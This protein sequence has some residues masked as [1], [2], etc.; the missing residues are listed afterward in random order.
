M[1]NIEILFTL[2]YAE[3]IRMLQQQLLSRLEPSV[4]VET[5][6][7]ERKAFDQLDAF[8]LDERFNRN[9]DTPISEA[10]HRRR[11]IYTRDFEKAFLLDREDQIRLL[12]DPINPYTRG[13]VAAANRKK[14]DLVIEA[15]DAAAI[16][17]KNGT[18]TT[19]FD[20]AFE[21]LAGGANMT[22]AKVRDAKQMLIQA[23][24]DVDDPM[25]MVSLVM[26]QDQ[27]T[28]LMGDPEVTSGD[29]NTN[30]VLVNGRLDQWYGCK[31]IQSERLPVTATVRSCFMWCKQSMKLGIGASPMSKVEQRSD[32]SYSTQAY[33]KHHYGA[34]RMDEKGVVRILCQ[35]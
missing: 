21:V 15:F 35:E 20:T 26:S 34:T 4:T 7:N 5:D 16:T 27:I 22:P 25:N 31:I 12:N 3:G 32:K 13:F 2:K 11:W 14:D 6:I 24:N 29:Y 19:A 1:G 18:G 10:D 8:E 33:A 30:R 9:A 28:S 23:E 17:G